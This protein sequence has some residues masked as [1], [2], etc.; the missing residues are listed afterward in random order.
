M[1]RRLLHLYGVTPKLTLGTHCAAW[2]WRQATEIGNT[3]WYTRFDFIF[4][5]LFDHL[6]TVH[7]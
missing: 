6:S 7:V 4:F 2:Y 5:V 3:P 1:S